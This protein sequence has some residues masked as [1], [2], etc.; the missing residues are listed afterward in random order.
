MVVPNYVP[1]P[2]EIPDNVTQQPYPVRLRFIR[3]MQG[4]QLVS[5]GVVGALSLLSQIPVLQPLPV[6]VTLLGFLIM[7]CFIRIGF[8]STRIEAAISSYTIPVLLVVVAMAVR[9]IAHVGIPLWAMLFGP[10]FAYIY[11]LLCG[12][13]F[14]FVGQLV[15]SS[16]VSSVAVASLSLV[17]GQ[18]GAYAAQ[19][20]G[21]NAIFLLYFVYD[22][23][24]L[25]SRRRVGEELAAV[26]DLYR[27]VLNI[28]GYIPRVVHHWHKH[29]IWQLR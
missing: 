2:I 16:I 20:L 25:L 5:L 10:A 23:A 13:D 12:R 27:D 26:T 9:S 29:R 18:Q 1:E 28:F 21:L 24:S 7:L 14:S 17:M 22:G 11:T 15:L 19:A 8:R 3:R 6:L 4:L